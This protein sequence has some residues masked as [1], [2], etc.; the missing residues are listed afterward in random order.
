QSFFAELFVRIVERFGDP[1]GVKRENIAGTERSLAD[2]T[3]PILE[4]AEDR[5]GGIEAIHAVV[6][7]QQN[8]AEMAAVRVSQTAG[9]LLVFG[10]KQ[11]GEAAVGRIFA[12]QLVDGAKNAL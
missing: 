3:I 9:G 2:H 4:Q 10:K 8:G 7:A 5:R 6:A 1:I 11:R 12:K